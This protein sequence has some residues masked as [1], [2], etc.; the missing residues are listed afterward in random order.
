MLPLVR[1]HEYEIFRCIIG[2]TTEISQIQEHLA[3]SIAD[4]LPE[5][6]EH[7][8]KFITE[9][10][11]ASMENSHCVLSDINID[12]QFKE[13]LDDL[14]TYGLTR[15]T[16]DYG[17]ETGF[18]LWHSYRMDQVQLK[19]LKNPKHNQ[20]GTYYY[21]DTVVIF[22]SLKK[23]ASVAER[24]KYKDKFIEPA[25]FQWESMADV[26]ASD[27]EKLENSKQTLL[28]IRKVS[29]ENGIV[30]PFTYVGIGHLTN[31]R[32]Q[33]GFDNQKNKKVT[34]YLF[35]IPMENELPDYLQY[36]F[37]LTK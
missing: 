7:A 23:D 34:T 32:K 8:M 10:G 37:G 33:V 13:Y 30:M 1:Q 35:D 19:L 9:N 24:L 12:D 18:K 6:F 17:T 21:G 31:P 27:L 2:G 15:Y 22:A 29:D 4:Y 20:V 16:V 5:Q 14:L 36:D 28:F 25:M 3:E 11:F 26:P